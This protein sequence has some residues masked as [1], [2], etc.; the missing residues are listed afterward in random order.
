MGRA[1]IYELNQLLR[2]LVGI[3]GAT[4][5]GF[6]R[7]PSGIFMASTTPRIDLFLPGPQCI[8]AR[9]SHFDT[10]LLSQSRM[11]SSS[12]SQFAVE[13]RFRPRSK[14]L[15]AAYDRIRVSDLQGGA[16]VFGRFHEA[17]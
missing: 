13:N 12:P 15:S 9:V 8:S 4:Q 1:I 10:I 6:R 17:V 2:A 14:V 16:Y 3:S 7:Q 11:W 5:I